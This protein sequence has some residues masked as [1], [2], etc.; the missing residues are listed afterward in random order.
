M[1]AGIVIVAAGK[2]ERL[3]AAVHKALVP[4]G[5]RP[6]LHHAVSR[7]AEAGEV[8]AEMAL[9]LHPDDLEGI[10][11]GPEGAALRELGVRHFVPGGARRQDS[12]LSGIRALGKDCEVVLVHDAARPFCRPSLVR[13]LIAALERTPGAVPVV[14]VTST[15][16]RA[17]AG[18]L[19][20]ET[21]DRS[22]LRLAQTPQAGRRRELTAALES[23]LDVTD[24]SQA[25]EAAGHAVSLVPDSPWN[26]KITT[27]ADLRLAELV[28]AHDLWKEDSA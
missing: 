1:R 11:S 14:P 25:L 28:W 18:Q 4:L 12:V 19:V 13:D 17:A 5:D 27:P 15:V 20:A 2:G 24:E 7:F 10:A 6:L 16:K 23:A 21:V 9:V 22:E 26:F 8:V 3:G